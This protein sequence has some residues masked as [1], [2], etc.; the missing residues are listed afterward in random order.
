MATSQSLPLPNVPGFTT[1][2]E[3]GACLMTLSDTL[4]RINFSMRDFSDEP[5]TIRSA[6]HSLA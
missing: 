6:P 5:T 4:P 2:T 3:Q 1:S